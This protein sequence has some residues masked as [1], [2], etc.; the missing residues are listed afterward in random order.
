[1]RANPATAPALTAELPGAPVNAEPATDALGTHA[2]IVAA[3]SLPATPP[4]PARQTPPGR[5]AVPTA[6]ATPPAPALVQT[7]RE[8]STALA[9]MWPV[10]HPALAPIPV[11]LIAIPTATTVR[12]TPAF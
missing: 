11:T 9:R 2:P 8:T 4:A 7:W 1:M 10:T 3:L 12:S 5:T 6:P